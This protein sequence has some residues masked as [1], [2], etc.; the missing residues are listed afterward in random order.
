[1]RYAP[2]VDRVVRVAPLAS[3]VPDGASLH[4]PNPLLLFYALYRPTGPSTTVLH[5]LACFVRSLFIF[6][7]APLFVCATLRYFSTIFTFFAISSVGFQG[8]SFLLGGLFYLF[9]RVPA[10]RW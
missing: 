10:G 9:V 3:W 4:T 2:Y 5:F 1:M 6:G 8:F 7:A